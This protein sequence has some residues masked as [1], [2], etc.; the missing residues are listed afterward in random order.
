LICGG[1][2]ENKKSFCD[3]HSDRK[4]EH[5]HY[6]ASCMLTDACRLNSGCWDHFDPE[7]PVRKERCMEGDC[8]AA[9][10]CK[11]G[12]LKDSCMEGDCAAANGC[13]HGTRKDSCMKGDCAA[14]NGCKHGTRKDRCM[15]GDCAAA[16]GCKH[17]SRKDSCTKG[18]CGQKR[19]RALVGRLRTAGGLSKLAESTAAGSG[20]SAGGGSGGGGAGGGVAGAY[21]AMATTAGPEIWACG[22]D[23]DIDAAIGDWDADCAEMLASLR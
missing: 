14:A 16:N 9:N 17:G 5:G 19:E 23:S 7:A 4:C 21:G 22:S 2:C 12:K 20:G 8:A 3:A 1:I 18:E 11:H 10:G 15:K 6:W 13:K